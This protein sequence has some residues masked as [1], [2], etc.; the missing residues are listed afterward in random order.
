MLLALP[1]FKKMVANNLEVNK[2]RKKTVFWNAEEKIPNL[3][4]CVN[5]YKSKTEFF[6]RNFNVDKTRQ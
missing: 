1:Y 4:R 3:I 2:N 5:N 6:N